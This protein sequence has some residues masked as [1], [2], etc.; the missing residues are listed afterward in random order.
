M[1]T[2]NV[3][4]QVDIWTRPGR[5]PFADCV[6]R[7]IGDWHYQ[8]ARGWDYTYQVIEDDARLFVE[9]SVTR[10]ETF[11]GEIGQGVPWRHEI[12]PSMSETQLVHLLFGMALGY[13]EHEAREAATYRGRR[14]FGPHIDIGAQWAISEDYEQ[15]GDGPSDLLRNDR[16][17]A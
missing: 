7:I 9:L 6:R 10:P 16:F 8:G 15:R 1:T 4:Y 2:T 11:G 13:D 17:E 12:F 3:R 5:A 14:V